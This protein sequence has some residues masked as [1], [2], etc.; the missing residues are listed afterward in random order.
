MAA[1]I[2]LTAPV[3]V[4][5]SPR[6]VRAERQRSLE[7]HL[8]SALSQTI[9]RAR[10]SCATGEAPANAIR[11]RAAGMTNAPDAA[12]VCVTVLTRLGREGP[13]GYVRDP[14][15]S[16]VRPALA[17]DQGFVTAW[18]NRESPAGLPTMAALKPVAERCLAQAEKDTDLC[19]S[20]GY[21]YGTRAA[22]GE[23]VVVQ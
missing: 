22:N 7:A 12:D 21:A 1:V 15:S 23:L 4:A 3:A 6:D 17:F 14:R 20:V 13:L 19:H 5:A 8:S 18:R 10:A 11:L 9:V 16:V 2:A